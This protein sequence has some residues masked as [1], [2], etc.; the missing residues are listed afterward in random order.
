MTRTTIRVVVP[1]AMMTTMTSAMTTPTAPLILKVDSQQ[2]GPERA[3]SILSCSILVAVCSPQ[4]FNAMA[5][6][7]VC[8]LSP[9]ASRMLGL[10]QRAPRSRTELQRAVS[11]AEETRGGCA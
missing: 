9:V 7:L 8:M 11:K 10:M 5:L 1:L 6:L 4:Q 3:H 2:T